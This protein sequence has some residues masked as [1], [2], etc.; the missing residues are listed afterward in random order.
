MWCCGWEIMDHLHNSYDL[1]PIEFHLFG[2][3]KKHLVGKRCATDATVKLSYPD[4]RHL[5][6]VFSVLG[7]KYC[8][9]GGTGAYMSMLTT[10]G[11]D[12]CPA[13]IKVSIKF[14]ATK[15]FF[16]SLLKLFFIIME[17]VDSC[18]RG[19]EEGIKSLPIKT[20]LD[21]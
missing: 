21:T 14:Y 7:Y 4:Y 13:C 8:C 5:T 6:P 2:C 10:W 11:S 19:R 3:L 15:H 16:I 17:H 12:V 9:H 18:F 20:T 1:V